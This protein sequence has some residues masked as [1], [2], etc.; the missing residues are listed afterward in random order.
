MAASSRDRR[1]IEPGG[2]IYHQA[3]AHRGGHEYT[4]GPIAWD[5]P[6]GQHSPCPGCPLCA[7]G[8]RP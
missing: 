1:A 6:D 2:A 3:V 5:H 7:N 4:G 8:P